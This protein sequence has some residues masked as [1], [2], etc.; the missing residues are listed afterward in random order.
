LDGFTVETFQKAAEMMQ[1]RKF[2][3]ARIRQ[4]AI[5]FYSLDSAIEKYE[6]IYNRILR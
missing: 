1:S 5:D 6:R 3:R 4:G 2:D